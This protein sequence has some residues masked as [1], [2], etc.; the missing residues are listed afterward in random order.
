MINNGFTGALA[1]SHSD[2]HTNST[3][4]HSG[5]S[6]TSSSNSSRNSGTYSQQR[7]ST[8]KESQNNMNMTDRTSYGGGSELRGGGATAEHTSY[9]VSYD[10]THGEI[11]AVGGESMHTIYTMASDV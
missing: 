6:K 4:L 3:P 2:G 7:T 9:N 5:S 10:A 8:P 11:P 1:I